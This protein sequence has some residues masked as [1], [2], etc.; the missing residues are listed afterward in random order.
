MNVCSWPPLAAPGRPAQASGPLRDL[1][2]LQATPEGWG[3]ASQAGL[4]FQ[5]GRGTWWRRR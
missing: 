2:R 3:A 1:A 4:P 5:E